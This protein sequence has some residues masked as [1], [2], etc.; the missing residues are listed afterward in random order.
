MNNLSMNERKTMDLQEKIKAQPNW[1]HKIELPG[2]IVT[3]GLG[4]TDPTRYCIPDDLTGMRVLDIGAW[5]GYWTWEAL[6]RGAKEVVAIDNFSDNLGSLYKIKRNKWETFDLC[7]EA[8]GFTEQLKHETWNCLTSS[9]KNA[10]EQKVSRIE[11]SVYEIE[12][13]GQF[14]VVFF[15]GTIYH[16]K[17]PLLAMEKISEVCNGAVYIETA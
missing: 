4:P 13:L 6:K 7:R 12:Q 15:F 9:W 5:D 16:L 1:Y 11:L 17:H 14:D 8:L 2:G 3:P 10:K